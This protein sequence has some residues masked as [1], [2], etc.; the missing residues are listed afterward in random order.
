LLAMLLVV[1]ALA[2]AQKKTVYKP[3]PNTANAA[4]G[5]S[6]EQNKQVARRVFDDL[7]TAGRYGE[8]SQIYDSNAGI[9]FGGRTESLSQSV[10][11]GK[12]WRSASPDLVMTANQITANGDTVTVNWTAHGTH[13]GQGHGLKPTGKHFMVHGQSTFRFA[14]GKIV[15]A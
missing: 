8:V 9:H 14:N 6:P 3:L 15:E 13:T 10:E 1:L 11:E 5:S 4:K 2:A 7:L 12:G